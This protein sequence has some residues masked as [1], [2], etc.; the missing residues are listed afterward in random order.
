MAKDKSSVYSANRGEIASPATDTIV[1]SLK[2]G[3]R[4]SLPVNH[5][6]HVLDF[7]RSGGQIETPATDSIVKNK[8]M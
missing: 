7:N 2:E 5:N 8:K 3:T 6:K 1:G 4:N